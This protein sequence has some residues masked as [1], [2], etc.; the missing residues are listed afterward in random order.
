MTVICNEL[1]KRIKDFSDIQSYKQYDDKYVGEYG[2]FSDSIVGFS[3]L[4][5]CTRS[6]LANIDEMGG[7]DMIF[8]DDENYYR[9]FLP[10]SLLKEVK[11]RPLTKDEFMRMFNNGVFGQW[12]T[13]KSI[14][15][16][17][18]YYMQ[19]TGCF[20]SELDIVYVCLGSLQFSLVNLFVD[21]RWKDSDGNWRVF[22]VEVKE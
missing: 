10:E 21:Y 4:D 17:K 16:E 19:F 8:D 2:Y 11:Y 5:S 13:M 14:I 12:I 18:E 22:G 9:F 6:V 15:T 3:D 1:D 20:T 7:T